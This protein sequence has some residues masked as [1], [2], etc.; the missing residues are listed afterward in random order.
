MSDRFDAG[1]GADATSRAVE[2]AI[3][4]GLLVLLVAWCYQIM[5]PFLVPLV[6]GVIIAVAAYPAFLRLSRALGGRRVVSAILVSLILLTALIVPAALLSGTLYDGVQGVAHRFQEGRIRIPPPP[7][8]VAEWP[9]IGDATQSYWLRA[10]ENLESTLAGFAP[11]LRSA[12]RWLLGAAAGA[13]FGLL[14]FVFAVAIAGALL[15]RAEPAKAAA[16]AV[17]RRLAGERGSDLA[18]L[19]EATV[20]SVTRGIIG[21][22]LIQALLAGLGFLAAGVPAAGLWALV[23][24]LLSVMQIG[25]FPVVI[26][27]VIYVFTSADTLTAVVFLIWS[28]FVG[29]ID[30][31]LKPILLGRGVAVPMMVV[32]LGAIGGFLSSGI[33]GLFV[34]PVVLVLSYKLF[35]AWLYEGELPAP[36]A[37]ESAA[38]AA[39]A[40]RLKG[41]PLRP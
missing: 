32:F 2:T 22:S 8:G 31:I 16:Q 28:L 33:V 26:P 4:I 37:V 19:A 34:G 9:L 25:V 38:T 3:R 17:A 13:G 18:A 5:E 6:W 1:P 39:E 41:S 10:S 24:L 15:A 7:P 36:E 29:S 35:L 12:G 27:M 14:Q 23:A 20:R 30:N 40:A 11:Q 21:V